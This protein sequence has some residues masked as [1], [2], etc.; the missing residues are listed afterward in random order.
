M[1][2]LI[3]LARSQSVLARLGSDARNFK[4]L[5]VGLAKDPRV[6]VRNKLIFGGMLAYVAMPVDL[7]PDWLPGI[8]RLDDA[9]V[10]CLAVDAML[11]HVP[12][13][14]IDAYWKGDKTS[15]EMV[16]RVVAAARE[17][18]PPTVAR[19]LYPALAQLR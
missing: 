15:L 14:V 12:E 9:I 16:R 11:N 6:P 4:R 7:I 17:F 3:K 5:A 18:L 1:G 8:G 13:T 19:T 10:F 2:E